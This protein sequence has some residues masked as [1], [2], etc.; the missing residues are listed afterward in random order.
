MPFSFDTSSAHAC[1]GL[2]PLVP[3]ASAG[4]APGKRLLHRGRRGDRLETLGGHLRALSR[5]PVPLPLSERGRRGTTMRPLTLRQRVG[6]TGLA[7]LASFGMSGMRWGAV[8]S[9]GQLLRGGAIAHQENLPEAREQG[10]QPFEPLIVGLNVD[11]TVEPRAVALRRHRGDTHRL[12][13]TPDPSTGR[14]PPGA[15]DRL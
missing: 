1:S 11:R 6:V 7:R 13:L 12:N 2:C 9:Q 8:L 10:P 4:W 14:P 5:H 15:A 3:W